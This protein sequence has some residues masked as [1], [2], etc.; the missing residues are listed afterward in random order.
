MTQ[1]NIMLESMINPILVG[2]KTGGH[3]LSSFVPI[4]PA[5]VDPYASS[6]F[7]SKAVCEVC[8]GWLLVEWENQKFRITLVI[9]DECSPGLRQPAA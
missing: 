3:K 8:G 9:A 6:D 1:N 4:L 2:L 5:V 7:S